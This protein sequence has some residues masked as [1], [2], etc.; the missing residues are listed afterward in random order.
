MSLG[1]LT[2]GQIIDDSLKKF[3]ALTRKNSDLRPAL[4]IRIPIDL[5]TARDKSTPMQI[6][7]PFDGFYVENSTTTPGAVGQIAF[8]GREHLSNYIQIG[9]NDVDNFEEP[10]RE[11]FFMNTAQAGVTLTLILFLG[12]RFQSGALNSQ[13]TGGVVISSGQSMTPKACVSVLTTATLIVAADTTRKKTTITN[14]SGATIWISGTNAVASGT[15]AVAGTT[16][17]GIPLG[18]GAIYEMTQTGAL[19]G[20]VDTGTALVSINTEI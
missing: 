7:G 5:S 9:Q 1:E 16:T 6:D 2:Q 20:I 3:Q 8:S 19:Y 14:L 4:V 18:A 13:I 17:V 11:L 15:S 12:M 10:I